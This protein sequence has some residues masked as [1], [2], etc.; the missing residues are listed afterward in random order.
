M[1]DLISIHNADNKLFVKAFIL[2]E[3]RAPLSSK[4]INEEHYSH[5]KNIYLADYISRLQ[6]KDIILGSDYF[7]SFDFAS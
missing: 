7:F 2:D 6:I 5:L 3:L 4:K 1:T